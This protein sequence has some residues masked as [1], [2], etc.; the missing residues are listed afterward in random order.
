MCGGGGD[1]NETVTTQQNSAPWSGQQPYLETGFQAAEDWFKGD[2]PSYFPGKTFVPNA[3]QT[4]Q[5]LAQTEQTATSGGSIGANAAGL[6]NRTVQGDYVNQD[7]PAFQGMVNRMDASIRPQIDAKFGA[8]GRSM[9]PAHAEAYSR[10]LTDAVAPLA[11][12][13]YDTERSRQMAAASP[14]AAAMDYFDTGQLASVGAANENMA[15]MDLQD[16]INRFNFDQNRDANRAAQYLSLIGGGY[17]TD[18]TTTQTVPSNR[19]GL[20]TGLGAG[21]TGV[22]ILGGLFGPFGLFS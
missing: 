3:P 8:S 7:N 15:N 14:Q 19:N 13:N 17:G 16:T 2:A 4:E 11:Y 22:G 21:A 6:L 12:Q 9:S 10:S 18:S 20:L 1:D 5:A